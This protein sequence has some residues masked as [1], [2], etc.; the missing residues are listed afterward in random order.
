MLTQAKADELL[1]LFKMLDDAATIKLPGAGDSLQLRARSEDGVEAFVIDV[2]RKGRIKIGK[3][4]YQERYSID[5]LLRLDIGGP[6]HQN[7]DGEEVPTP[8]MHI[9]KEGYGDT[10]AYPIPALEEGTFTNTADLAVT[11]REFLAFC[12]VRNIPAIDGGLF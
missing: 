4:T 6:P 2:N 3:C 10:W 7:P 5:I 9:Y 1:G 11:L 12:K 8:H